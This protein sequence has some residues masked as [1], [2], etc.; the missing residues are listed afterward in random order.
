MSTHI[1][2]QDDEF[3]QPMQTTE[4]AQP[5]Q[6]EAYLLR[7]WR[8]DGKTWHASLQAVRTG[9][10]HMFADRESLLTFLSRQLGAAPEEENSDATV[11]QGA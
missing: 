9:E 3:A 8:S 2:N 5:S 4:T 6:Y 1:T 7:L 11:I 10:R